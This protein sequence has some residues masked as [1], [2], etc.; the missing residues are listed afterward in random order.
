MTPLTRSPSGMAFDGSR[1][2][3]PESM[4]LQK[5][6]GDIPE[7]SETLFEGELRGSQGKGV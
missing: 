5:A 4:A 1:K 2:S 7:T 3:Y 6:S